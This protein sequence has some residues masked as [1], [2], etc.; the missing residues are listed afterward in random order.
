MSIFR[1]LW[2]GGGLAEALVLLDIHFGVVL[3][4]VLSRPIRSSG[5]FSIDSNPVRLPEDRVTAM[6]APQDVFEAIGRRGS[7]S[8][9]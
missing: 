5:A 3:A 7:H 4:S 1:G 6:M 2:R 9:T 8:Y